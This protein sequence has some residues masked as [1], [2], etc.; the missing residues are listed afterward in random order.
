MTLD[1]AS[2]THATRQGE[3]KVRRG[4]STNVPVNRMGKD[5]K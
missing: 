5:A 1:A 2:R 3:G 4:G